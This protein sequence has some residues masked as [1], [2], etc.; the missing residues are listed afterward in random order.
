MR[1]PNISTYNIATYR[2]GKLTED[3][4]DANEVVSTQKRIN[5]IS[6]D[7]LGLSQV[8][9]LRNSLGNLEQIEQNVVMGKSWLQG[10]E[11]ALDSV[12][13]LI[14][15]AK[16]EA[17]RLANDSTTADER[18]DAVERVENIIEQIVSLGNTQVNG[19]YV[20]GGTETDVVPFEYDTSSDPGQVLYHGNGVPFEIR[21]DKN[22]EVQ[23]GRD[24]KNT[25][26]D[27][28][29]EI[30]ATNNIIVFKED[31]GHG[32]ASQKTMEAR[33]PHGIYTREELTTAVRNALNDESMSSGYGAEY[34]VAY[35][36]KNQTFSIREDGSFNGYLR[37][38]FMWD[39]GG[40]PY[41]NDIAT[42]S[43]IDPDDVNISILNPDIL[44]IGTPEPHG[45]EPFK[46]IWDGSA[47]WNV[48]GNPGYV[49]PGKISGMNDYIE[50]DLD[51]SGFPDITIRLDNNVVQQGESIEFEIIPYQGDNSVGHE[52]GFG[53][54][55][56][57]YS[58]PVSDT[59]PVF[60]TDLTITG[61]V[62]DTID[63]VEVNSTGGIS[64][65]LSA[66]ITAGNYTDM[67]TLAKDIEN[68]LEAASAA[69]TSGANTIDYAVSYDV[70]NSRFNIREDGTSLNEL[71]VLWSNT[72]GASTTAATLGYFAQDD[73]IAYPVSD[74]TP[75]HGAIA[76][77]NTNN[78]I[79]FQETNTAG[80]S[81]ILTALVSSGV[82]KDITALETAVETAMNNASAASG[83]IVN[84]DVSYTDTPGQFEIQRSSGTALTGFDI[85]WA[86]GANSLES[87]G[88]TLGYD[89]AFDDGGGMAHVSD[90]APILMTFDDTNN[91]IEF[92]ETKL[93]G[94]VSN[95]IR[96]EIP[97]MDYTD[98]DALAVDIQTSLRN[99]SPNGVDY[100]VTYDFTAGQFMIKGSDA[101][102]KGFDLLWNSGT[103]AADSAA[104]M[105]GFDPDED[106][107][108]RFLESDTEIVNLVIDPFNNK[109]DF[110]EFTPDD[111]GKNVSNLT[112]SIRTKIYTSYEELASEVEIALEAESLQNG[113][114]IDYS[115]F[116]D[117]YTKK[118]SIKENGTELEEFHLQWQSGDNAPLSLGGTDQSIGAILGFNPS[119]D[120]ETPVKSRPEVEWGIFNTLIDLETY[121]SDN[122]VDGIERSIGRL[123]LNYNNMT[124]RIV[125]TGMKFSRL[126]VREDI[127]TEISLSLTE[128]KTRIEDADII[129]SIMNLQN[130]ELAYQAALSATSN[131]LNLSL[132]DY[133]R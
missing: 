52:I 101:E 122:D 36:E 19:N 89:I 130:I 108:V 97:K 40:E 5:E 123:E 13:N 128:R 33:I 23:V 82:Y 35:D 60:I 80:T 28:N 25:F 93:N 41:I 112:A 94:G 68:Q 63:F 51:E 49:I 77:D 11:T 50:I 107:F 76:I 29:I 56:L 131:V 116:W 14:L 121:L 88:E 81:T 70:E 71:R 124:S 20:F 95:E 73:T 7:P 74:I 111:I 86:T 117:D 12:N 92:M 15:D 104:E 34:L 85:L 105:L 96:I 2:L 37:T 67:D 99:A 8:L 55:D 9:S 57:T 39:T 30:N 100:T 65:T 91:V 126:Q 16:S 61:G 48:E 53:L 113:N 115:V 119:D 132:V 87:I 46:L 18:I 69:P 58:P 129:E 3:L 44:T 66:T 118:F 21:T 110:K 64:A 6:D 10:V 98:L 75:I 1:V 43:L 90:T 103:N 62:N 17:M 127:T 79:D 114:K 26:W 47:G 59:R 54:D 120:I 32:S 38:Q 31:N 125:D 83:N 22:S 4:K 106:D 133:L 24:G 42:S 72:T 84:Y 109:I 45:T 102:I 78:K 27:T